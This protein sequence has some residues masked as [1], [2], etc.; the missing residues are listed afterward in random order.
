MRGTGGTIKNRV[1]QDVKYKN[2][3]IRN[4]ENFASYVN[5]ILKGTT[6]LYMPLEEVLAEQE[7]VS[8][9]PKMPSTLEMLKIGR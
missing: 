6:S 4:A 8:N 1:F 5:S 9:A 2:E 3:N 7:S